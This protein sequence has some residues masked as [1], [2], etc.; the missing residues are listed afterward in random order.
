VIRI[1]MNLEMKEWLSKNTR[2]ASVARALIQAGE[3]N[4]L[5][6][7]EIGKIAHPQPLT[8]KERKRAVREFLKNIGIRTV[9]SINAI[10]NDKQ[11]EFMVVSVPKEG[12]N[13]YMASGNMSTAQCEHAIDF[14]EKQENAFISNSELRE[15][16][17][18][19]LKKQLPLFGKEAFKEH[20]L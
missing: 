11:F 1:M 8:K 20:A 18:N 17:L 7:Y 14:Y 2:T 16:K 15:I 13:E 4:G 6:S 19:N 12:K 10:C 3:G 5:T 9:A